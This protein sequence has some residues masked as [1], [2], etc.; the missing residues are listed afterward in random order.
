MLSVSEGF[1]MRLQQLVTVVGAHAEG[2]VGRVITGGVLAPLASSMFECQQKIIAEQ[3]WLRG[4]LLSDLRRSVNAAV[5]LITYRTSVVE[6]KSVAGRVDSG[7]RRIF[8]K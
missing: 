7:G 8:K 6:G 1:P 4:M 2:E 5:H 3:D